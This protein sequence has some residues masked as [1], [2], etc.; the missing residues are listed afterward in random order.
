MDS[1]N[2]AEETMPSSLS[3]LISLAFASASSS[4]AQQPYFS[5]LL[6]FNLDCL[7]K[8]WKD[9][10]SIFDEVFQI[11]TKGFRSDLHWCALLASSLPRYPFVSIIAALGFLLYGGRM[12]E[13]AS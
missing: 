7:Q 10:S 2:A 8:G 11:I 6:S 13:E 3:S 12:K 9:T 5:E 4:S 1:K